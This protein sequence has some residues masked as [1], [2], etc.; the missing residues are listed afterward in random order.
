VA[1]HEGVE[2][3]PVTGETELNKIGVIPHGLA[4]SARSAI[5]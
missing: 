4:C 5:W 2:S 1:G 3:V